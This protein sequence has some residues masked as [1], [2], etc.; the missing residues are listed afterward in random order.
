MFD[1]NSILLVVVLVVSL[2]G[3]ELGVVGPRG[4]RPHL[5]ALAGRHVIRRGVHVRLAED[6]QTHVRVE[7]D[8]ARAGAGESGER[9]KIVL[10]AVHL[11]KC[12]LP[13]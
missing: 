6:D 4:E 2:L 5:E 13:V 7:V 12:S 11:R 3:R 9:I 8:L 1:S 10:L